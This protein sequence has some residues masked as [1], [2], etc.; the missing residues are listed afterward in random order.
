MLSKKYRL[1]KNGSFAYVYRKGQSQR[2]QS[3]ALTFVA[4][5]GAPRVGFSVPNKVGKAVVRNK[6]RRRLRAIVQGLM[7][8]LRGAQIV[9]SAKAGADKLTYGQLC[10]CVEKLFSRA[11]LFAS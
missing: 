6:L 3:L 8:R 5:K 7:P 10:D 4:G 1:T 11:G 9:L 2:E